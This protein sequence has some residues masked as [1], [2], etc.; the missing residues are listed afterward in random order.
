MSPR[1]SA[2]PCRREAHG[3]KRVADSG[4]AFAGRLRGTGGSRRAVMSPLGANTNAYA[5]S[6]PKRARGS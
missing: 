2:R 3:P 4:E 6:G 1:I 5:E